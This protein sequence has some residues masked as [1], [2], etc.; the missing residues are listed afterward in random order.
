[1][2]NSDSASVR[3]FPFTASVIIDQA[4]IIRFAECKEPGEA[5]DQSVWTV[6]LAA[7]RA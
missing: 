2:V 1:M 6:A 3:V 4:G 5:R 7:L